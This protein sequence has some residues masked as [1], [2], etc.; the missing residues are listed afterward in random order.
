MTLKLIRPMKD[1]AIVYLSKYTKENTH[2]T[3]A[4]DQLAVLHMP[5]GFCQEFINPVGF[6]DL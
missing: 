2:R 5:E 4:R 6:V 1:E 3:Q